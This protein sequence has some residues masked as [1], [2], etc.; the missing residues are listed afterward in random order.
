MGDV[1]CWKLPPV[2]RESLPL[3]FLGAI[4]V[5]T[6]PNPWNPLNSVEATTK[7]KNHGANIPGKTPE[8]PGKTP[9]IPGKT[10]EIPGLQFLS[11]GGLCFC[12]FTNCLKMF[13]CMQSGTSRSVQHHYHQGCGSTWWVLEGSIWSPAIFGQHPWN[14]M[15]TFICRCAAE[16]PENDRNSFHGAN[17]PQFRGYFFLRWKSPRKSPW[18]RNFFRR[19]L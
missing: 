4:P 19:I 14:I 8:I 9:E 5:W 18:G 7:C 2:F 3:R 10:A 1:F 13:R 15:Q 11:S 6:A 17:L 16:I 12:V